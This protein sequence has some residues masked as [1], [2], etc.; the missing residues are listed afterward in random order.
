MQA[1]VLRKLDKMQ[2][3]P[4]PKQIKPLPRPDEEVSE[5]AREGVAMAMAW[6]QRPLGF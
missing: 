6:P 1:E 5:R 2:E 4:P 3:P